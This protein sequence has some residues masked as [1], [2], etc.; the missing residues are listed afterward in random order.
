MTRVA[1]RSGMPSGSV[2]ALWLAGNPLAELPHYRTMAG[3][4]VLV[5]VS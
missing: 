3:F 2:E 5:Q 1:A 4:Q